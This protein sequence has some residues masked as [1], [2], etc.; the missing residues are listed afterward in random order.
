MAEWHDFSTAWWPGPLP[1]ATSSEPHPQ[2]GKF[3]FFICNSLAALIVI[4]LCSETVSSL[5]ILV[6]LEVTIW[7]A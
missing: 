2:F 7:V 6:S 4:L 3:Y 5:A 1:Q